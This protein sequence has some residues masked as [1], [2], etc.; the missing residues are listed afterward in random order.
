MN[1][2]VSGIPSCSVVE[3]ALRLPRRYAQFAL[4][5]IAGED[6]LDAPDLGAAPKAGTNQLPG[7]GGQ[8]RPRSH[9]GGSQAYRGDNNH[10]LASLRQRP[11]FWSLLLDWVLRGL[12]YLMAYSSAGP[13]R[14]LDFTRPALG[15]LPDKVSRA[16]LQTHAAFGD[17]CWPPR[18]SAV[19]R[20]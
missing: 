6:D 17:I 5:G 9:T 12:L 7:A 15:G 16:T 8:Q 19:G 13:I 2:P 10:A 14:F 1:P 11:R 20:G 3:G 4:V 18:G